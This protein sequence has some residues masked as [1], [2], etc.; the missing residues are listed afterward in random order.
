MKTRPIHW[1]SVAAFAAAFTAAAAE[2]RT[3]TQAKTG[4]TLEA[5]F[6]KIAGSQVVLKLADGKT[7]VVPLNAL[8]EEDQ[9]F[10]R[11]AAGEAAAAAKRKEEWEG[12]ADLVQTTLWD[13]HLCCSK[14]E[15]QIVAAGTKAAK[16]AVDIDK[17]SKS[18]L[19]RAKSPEDLQKAVTAI[20]AAGFYGEAGEGDPASIPDFSGGTSPVESATFQMFICCDKCVASIQGALGKVGGVRDFKIERSDGKVV[21][22]GPV[23]PA[24]VVKEFRAA[25]L[26]AR[27]AN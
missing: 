5:E 27:L 19:V 24:A 6:V 13:I 26:N 10:A 2:A 15:Q 21:V 7:T 4:K 14:C 1:L 9:K 16:V 3:W 8:S 17:D 12:L 23:V 11:E 22:T 20:G 18:V 25:G